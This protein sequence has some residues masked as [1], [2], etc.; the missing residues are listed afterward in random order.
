[1]IYSTDNT[2]S[3]GDRADATPN[4]AQ[5]PKTS[6]RSMVS[7]GAS[8]KR[9]GAA[10]GR[11]GYAKIASRNVCNSSAKAEPMSGSS[12]RALAGDASATPIWASPRLVAVRTIA[13]SRCSHASQCRRAAWPYQWAAWACNSSNSCAN[14]RFFASRSNQDSRHP[15]S[16]NAFPPARAMASRHRR[17]ELNASFSEVRRCRFS[18]W[19]S[20]AERCATKSS[21]AHSNAI[22]T[23]ASLQRGWPAT[24]P[25][26]SAA[27]SRRATLAVS[28]TPSTSSKGAGAAASEAFASPSPSPPRY[29]SASGPSSPKPAARNKPSSSRP[30]SAAMRAFPRRT[31]RNLGSEGCLAMFPSNVHTTSKPRTTSSTDRSEEQSPRRMSI[32]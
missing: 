7:T 15:P 5:S 3:G 16:H 20:S 32:R 27:R 31:R 1:M 23:G 8:R 29:M 17:G 22:A 4:N 10:P 21:K 13:K 14:V 28:V 11:S 2:A 9:V 30:R 6:P 19:A 26:T 12:G 24:Q 18:A 25:P